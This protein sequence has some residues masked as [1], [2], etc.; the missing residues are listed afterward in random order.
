MQVSVCASV[1][2]SEPVVPG[3][4]HRPGEGLEA[5]DSIRAWRGGRAR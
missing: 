3:R 5:I 1:R 4:G 2:W